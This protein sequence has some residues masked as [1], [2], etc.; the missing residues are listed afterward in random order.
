MTTHSA[1]IPLDLLLR[2]YQLDLVQITNLDDESVSRAPVQWVHGSD[3]LDPTPFLTPRTVLLTTGSQFSAAPDAAKSQR[4]YVTALVNAGVCALG[5]AVNFSY[6]RIPEALIHA[7]EQQKL[8]LFRVPY[9]TPFIAISQTAARLLDQQSHARDA[10]SIAAQRAVA[11]AA[12]QQDGMKAVIRELSIQLGS[13][14]SIYDASGQPIE[15]APRQVAGL[16][17]APWLLDDIRAM[18][19]NQTRA[20]M[21][22]RRGSAQVTLQTLGRGG[23]L[24]GVLAVQNDRDLDYAAQSVISIVV[25]LASLTLEQNSSA[26]TATQ[27]LRTSI[28]QLILAG[29]LELAQNIATEIVGTLPSEPVIFGMLTPSPGERGE[30]FGALQ[31]LEKSLNGALFLAPS[32]DDIALIYTAQSRQTVLSA[33]NKLE[34]SIGLSEPHPYAQAPGALRQASTAHETALSRGEPHALAFTPN[35]LSG[36]L[37]LLTENQ[38]A[39]GR[40]RALLEPLIL[41]DQRHDEDLLHTLEAWLGENGQFAPAAALL[42]IHRHT[43]KTR[44]ARIGQLIGRDV[45]N[46]ATRAELWASLRIASDSH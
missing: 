15:W 20:S 24:L 25:A 13:W 14:V 4:D 46:F 7:C 8:P 26:S 42:G 38:E 21:P 6:E 45:N 16:E 44:I 17:T 30:L 37:E 19:R 28:L 31:T 39:P 11:L 36:V 1:T 29:Q 9:S 35:M 5:F 18:L 2:Q 10:W 3:L 32:E 33:L 43:L 34:V 41:N 12:L 23:N 22:S 27:Q 40:A